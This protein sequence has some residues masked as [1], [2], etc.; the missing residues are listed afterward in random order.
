MLP[1]TCTT[2]LD[3]AM[4]EDSMDPTKGDSQASIAATEQDRLR[5]ELGKISLESDKLRLE[6]ARAKR[7]F[8]R[9]PE[10]L[11]TFATALGVF[12]GIGVQ[13][14]LSKNEYLLAQV[15]KERAEMKVEAAHAEAREVEESLQGS[16]RANADLA[17]EIETNIAALQEVLAAQGHAKSEADQA[18]SEA[19]KATALLLGAQRANADLTEKIATDTDLLDKV[20]KE[21]DQA[22]L[23]AKEARSEARRAE[24]I[25]AAARASLE[26]TRE[27]IKTAMTLKDKL[28]GGQELTPEEVALAARLLGDVEK[29]G[30]ELFN[31]LYGLGDSPREISEAVALMHRAEDNGLDATR[32]IQEVYETATEFY[33]G[34]ACSYSL[35]TSKDAM[36]AAQAVGNA[37]RA[38]KRRE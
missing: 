24:E 31:A 9:R 3:L 11:V 32:T 13:Y 2:R 14:S 4:V 34:S 21:R 17:A 16:Q 29:G 18:R 27:A 15:Q 8:Y 25:L 20:R 22:E 30:E 26:G 19:Q 35:E 5:L 10:I 38:S 23:S 37:Y 33:L 7:P 6:I 12:L 28:R 1:D 36:L